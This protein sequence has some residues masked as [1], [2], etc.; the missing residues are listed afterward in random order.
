MLGF[1]SIPNLHGERLEKVDT[2]LNFNAN[3]NENL[4]RNVLKKVAL[5]DF[6]E[7]ID[8]DGNTV[9]VLITADS[10][11]HWDN[12]GAYIQPTDDHSFVFDLEDILKP[13][14]MS[15]NFV[16]YTDKDLTTFTFRKIEQKKT[17][18][19]PIC[20]DMWYNQPSLQQVYG[21][22]ILFAGLA[23]L[24]ITYGILSWQKDNINSVSA[25]IT[26]ISRTSLNENFY[27]S[28]S[29]ELSELQDSLSFKQFDSIIMKD[30]NN[31][32]S[33]AGFSLESVEFTKQDKDLLLVT[34][35]SKLHKHTQFSV[36]E[37]LAKRVLNN[38]TF[39]TAIRK[40]L[41][42]ESRL[43]LEA[44]VDLTEAK[45]KIIKQSKG[46]R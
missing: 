2:I 39:I 14:P 42:K 38:S 29:K 31:A 17:I 4:L 19:V 41:S 6:A 26:E 21:N 25:Q 8:N 3:V 33:L 46:G 13:Y 16:V 45:D 43:E 24:A 30:I 9:H 22:Y 37:P 11:I 12:K 35:K 5:I 15:D 32:I 18:E 23:M 44:L 1:F 27:N 34:I 7:A 28:S 36:Q 10:I 20:Q 40:K